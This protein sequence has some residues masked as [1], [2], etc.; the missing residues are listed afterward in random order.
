MNTN[1]FDCVVIGAGPG[2][3][4]AAIKAAQLGLKTAVIEREALGGICL[5]W[6][7]IPTKALLKSAEVFQ[8]V[9]SAEEFGISTQTIRANFPEIIAR[10]R[11]LVSKMTKG[12]QY[13]LKK[14]KIEVIFGHA[15]FENQHCV[16]VISSSNEVQ[17][18]SFKNAIIA[19]GTRAKIL[20]GLSFDGEKIITA[21]EA[22]TLSPAPKRILIIGAGAIGVE[23]AYFYRSFGVDVSIVEI[24]PNILPL[25]DEEVSNALQRSLVKQGMHIYTNTS[26]QTLTRNKDIVQATL[27]QKEKTIDWTGDYCLMAVGVRGNIESLGL[28]KL[29]IQYEESFIKVNTFYQTNLSNIY[30]VGDIIGSLLLAHVASHEGISAA[31]HI[32][33]HCPHPINYNSIPTCTYCKPQVASIGLTEKKAKEQGKKV[34]IGKFPFS[35]SGKAVANSESEGFVKVIINEQNEEILG[36]HIL[37]ADATELIG[38]ASVAISHEATASSL[39]NTIHAHPTLSEAI[40]EAMANAIGKAVHL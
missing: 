4:V 28:E 11:Q 9:C 35:A 32:A 36:V 2:G 33:G 39:A 8:T 15:S 3:Y 27:K 18:I 12:V 24:L 21:R 40:S 6:G 5:N 34:C 38:E 16:K 7:C 1:S 31:E 37:H 22:L 23:F 29:G 14:N 30:A 25:E 13:L 17:T 26:V 20:P 10:S 19:A